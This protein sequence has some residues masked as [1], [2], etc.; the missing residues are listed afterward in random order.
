MEAPLSPV[1]SRPSMS[2][3]PTAFEDVL[4]CPVCMEAFDLLRRVPQLLHSSHTVC[5][6]CID[7]LSLHH[8]SLHIRCP[9]CQTE[10]DSSQRT[11]NT[12]VC[13][14]ME[15]MQQQQRHAAR[16]RADSKEEEEEEKLQPPSPAAAAATAD[17]QEKEEA[18]QAALASVSLAAS[19]SLS[20]AARKRKNKQKNKE[21]KSSASLTAASVPPS[22]A[23]SSSSAASASAASD[24]LLCS[25]ASPKPVRRESRLLDARLF[26]SFDALPEP[27]EENSRVY[28][29][30]DGR[31]C[32]KYHWAYMGQITLLQLSRQYV[33]MTVQDRVG[34]RVSC[35]VDRVWQEV[36]P[37]FFQVGFTLFVRY[38]E[39]R[40]IEGRLGD[41]A[42]V[43]AADDGTLI[44]T[45]PA[46]LSDVLAC[47]QQ[48]AERERLTMAEL[49]ELGCSQCKVRG[50]SRSC[51]GCRMVNYCSADCQAR[52]MQKHRT[53]CRIWELLRFDI[54]AEVKEELQGPPPR[55]FSMSELSS[56]PAEARIPTEH[57]PFTRHVGS[58]SCETPLCCLRRLS[59]SP[60]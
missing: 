8:S 1:I 45:L 23:S 12:L 39:A 4:Q 57:I 25:S 48:L 21:E 22:A 14:L 53:E 59:L 55:S 30:R 15:A 10:V 11:A 24:S 41:S 17:G 2:A 60:Q 56:A 52:H 43:L 58:E 40:P 38:A 47:D 5:A 26:P 44:T 50:P 49:T 33:S 42:Y 18:E 19:P 32:P 6:A 54:H 13:Q 3:P 34:K 31:R 20:K 51:A 9:Q 16:Q 7:Q 28:V 37:A 27:W 35:V 36:N 29:M 46:P